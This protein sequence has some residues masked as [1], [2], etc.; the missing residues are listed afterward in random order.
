MSVQVISIKRLAAYRDDRYAQ[1][2]N[3][4]KLQELREQKAADAAKRKP[5]SSKTKHKPRSHEKAAMRAAEAAAAAAGG[6]APS[7]T[8]KP[9]VKGGKEHGEHGFLS[10]QPKPGPNGKGKKGG[11]GS[12]SDAAGPTTGGAAAFNGHLPAEGRP[13]KKAKT[14]TAGGARSNTQAG[15]SSCALGGI[16]AK[17][18][19]ALDPTEKAARAKERR[20][21]SFAPLTLRKEGPSEGTKKRKREA[22][23]AAAAPATAPANQ[24][25]GLSKEAKRR[26]R[27]TAKRAAK[28][29]IAVLVADV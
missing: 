20:L 7:S 23:E 25:T 6:T 22:A 15:Q 24:P 1:R 14:G 27:R 21:Q 9:G 29:A 12:R 17:N 19:M 5:H 13:A 16:A 18:Q 8:A 2:P 10:G 28:R 4:Q 26:L 11:K 3:W